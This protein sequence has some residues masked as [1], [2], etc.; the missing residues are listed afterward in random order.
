[1]PRATAR[2]DRREERDALMRL[3]RAIAAG[4]D[5]EGARLIDES[6]A[7]ARHAIDTGATRQSS[8]RYFLNEIGRQIYAGDTA[9]HIAAAAHSPGLSARLI[10]AGADVRARNRRGAEPIHY[11]ADGHPGSPAWHPAA[12]AATVACLIDAGADPNAVNKTGVTP[13]HRAVRTRA[14]AAVRTLLAKGADRDRANGRGSTAFDL[15]RRTTGRSG[16]GSAAAREQQQAIIALLQESG[17]ATP[18]ATR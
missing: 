11:S 3:F 13:L 8:S 4:D 6:P 7:L 12:Q 18:R 9:L 17:A 5:Q 14:A 2:P 15:A 16:S 10:A 1:M